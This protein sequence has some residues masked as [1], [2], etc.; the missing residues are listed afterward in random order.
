MT[1]RESFSPAE[2]PPLEMVIKYDWTPR[3]DRVRLEA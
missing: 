3:M 1:T 2:G